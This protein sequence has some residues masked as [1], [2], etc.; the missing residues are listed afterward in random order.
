MNK[1]VKKFK[2]LMLVLIVVSLLGLSGCEMLPDSWELPWNP[3]STD[4]PQLTDIPQ[5]T[6]EAEQSPNAS[7]ALTPTRKADHLAA[8]RT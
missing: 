7:D 2:L 1:T 3:A 8:A 5:P 4:N 6:S